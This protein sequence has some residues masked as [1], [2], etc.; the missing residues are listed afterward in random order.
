MLDSSSVDYKVVPSYCNSREIIAF[1]R[2][3]YEGYKID[4]T[5][6]AG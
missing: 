3:L 5:G 1:D 4:S 6:V 2:T